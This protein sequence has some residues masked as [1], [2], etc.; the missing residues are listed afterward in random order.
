MRGAVS[1]PGNTEVQ[2]RLPAP[3]YHQINE[4]GGGVPRRGLGSGFLGRPDK[5]SSHLVLQACERA[6]EDMVDEDKVEFIC[7]GPPM[8]PL[9]AS[10]A[11]SQ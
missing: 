7:K 8:C 4:V 11:E 3:S 10:A 2:S 6:E 9:G 5:I 1:T